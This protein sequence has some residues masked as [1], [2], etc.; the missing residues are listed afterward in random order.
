MKQIP[1]CAPALAAALLAALGL[2]AC[3]GGGD[4]APAGPAAPV[5]GPPAAVSEVPTSAR[6]SSTGATA[7]VRSTAQAASETA[8]PL[9]IGDATLAA[10]DSEEPEAL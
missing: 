3:G 6:T 5:E 4:A 1:S 9:V 10:S 8:E 7:F 2:A